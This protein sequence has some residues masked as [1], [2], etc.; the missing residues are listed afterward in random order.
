MAARAAWLHDDSVMTFER[1]YFGDM[2]KSRHEH[3]WYF[4]VIS[5]YCTKPHGVKLY[6]YDKGSSDKLECWQPFKYEDPEAM[7]VKEIINSYE[8][9]SDIYG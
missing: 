6:G 5:I 4:S 7:S 2:S 8:E 9:W 3:Q 1:T